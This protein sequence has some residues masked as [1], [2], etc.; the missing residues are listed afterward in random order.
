[1]RAT[2]FLDAL[3]IQLQFRSWIYPSRTSR[4]NALKRHRKLSVVMLWLYYSAAQIS[5]SRF[6]TQPENSPC[7]LTDMEVAPVDLVA[8]LS[9]MAAT[10][11]H[12]ALLIPLPAPRACPGRRPPRIKRRADAA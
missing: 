4:V 5:R 2:R 6:V 3:E 11:P 8:Q 9:G 10:E 12:Q 1:M 7:D